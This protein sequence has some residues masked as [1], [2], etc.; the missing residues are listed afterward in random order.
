MGAVHERAVGFADVD[1]AGTVFFPRFLAWC[2]EATERLF[3][4]LPGGYAELV[5][6]RRIGF[7]TVHVACDWRSPLR[8]GDVARHEVTVTKLGATSVT[9]R[10]VIARAADGRLV[11][12]IE[13]V[14]V[15]T[16]IDAMAKIPVPDDCRALLATHQ[17]AT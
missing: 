6:R 12:T 16:D 8:Y 10:H 5:T 9:L 15:A 1:A 3:E 4:P 2:H 17:A 11:A 14:I 7:P 13:H